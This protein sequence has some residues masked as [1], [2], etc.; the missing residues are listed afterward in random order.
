MS[1]SDHQIDLLADQ[2][3][4][5]TGAEIASLIR[6]ARTNARKAERDLRLE[7][8]QAAADRV[9]PPVSDALMRRV[10]VHEA[11]HL[12]SGHALGLPAATQAR[13]G[14]RGGEV[15]R[16][17]LVSMTERDIHA[18]IATVL[19]GREAEDIF[20][21][22]ISSGGGTGSSSDLAQA[23]SLAI[24]AECAFGF[25]QSLSWLSPDTPLLLLPEP[26]RDRVEGRLRAGQDE[27]RSILTQA[28]VTVERVADALN[29]RRELDADAITALLAEPG[30][31]WEEVDV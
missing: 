20:F 31:E 5:L 8:L 23:T 24:G 12:V 11:A 13:I 29:A 15:I 17:R 21:G 27:V 10:A 19:A 25:G 2:L 22:D 14:P 16:S 26:V 1:M 4:G 18:M 6:E 3:L 30:K 9:Q 7:D 28:R